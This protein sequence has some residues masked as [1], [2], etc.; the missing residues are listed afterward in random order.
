MLS[1]DFEQNVVSRDHLQRD[2][3]IESDAIVI[4]T[5]AG[6][7]VV[8]RELAAAG[9]SVSILEEGSYLSARDYGK[10]SPLESIEMLYR[11]SGL[12]TTVGNTSIILPS[13]KC[14]GGST[15]I[16]SGTALRPL[17]SSVDQWR[18]EFGLKQITD[19]LDFYATRV[20]QFLGIK[21]VPQL[22]AINEIFRAGAEKMGYGGSV[23]TR[24]EKGCKGAGRC[25]LGCPNDAKQAM[26]V[27]YVPDALRRG[28]K[29][30]PGVRAEKIRFEKGRAVGVD[31]KGLRFRAAHVIVSAGAVFTPHLVRRGGQ[32]LK[33][34]PATRVVGVF[35]REVHG[36]EGVPQGYHVDQFLSEGVSVEGIF[37]PPAL[38]APMLPV[39]EFRDH[40]PNLSMLGC[41]IIEETE[42]R[43]MY[44]PLGDWPILW[45]WMKE[46]DVDRVRRCVLISSEILF[47]A[48]AEKVYTGI[49]SF[50][51]MR[52][53]DLE[54]LRTEKLDVGDIELTAYHA[55]GT[56]RFSGSPDTGVADPDGKVWDVPG[57]YVADASSLPSSPVANPQVSI[58]IFAT[59]VAR[60]ILESEGRALMEET[61]VV[62]D[63]SH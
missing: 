12:T 62:G 18:A 49:D 54:R 9:M 32:H 33:I 21:P 28:A 59:H 51:C 42:G 20:E 57:L 8:A 53:N 52:P 13:G 1:F 61:N 40:Y 35:D 47:A 45:Y 30:Y 3:I 48:G 24:N 36:W 39:D 2:S 10:A 31:A 4:G 25:Y 5:G 60:K 34:H 27:S 56:A 6:G 55:Q 29:L 19:E 17:P 50:H 22:N 16:N 38:L 23:L 37:L 43:V 63:H 11:Q 26:N 7:A 44:N 14:V 46:V 15:V 58:M 41:R